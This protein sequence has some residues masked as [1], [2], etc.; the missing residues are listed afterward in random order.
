MTYRNGSGTTLARALGWF[1]IGLGA[2]E[3]LAPR[4]LATVLGMQGR[5]RL[6]Q[7]YGVR[8]VASGT[9]ILAARDP[10]PWVWIRVAGD[11]LDLATLAPALD[12]SN[13]RRQAAAIAV[14]AVT[15]VMLVDLLC[16]RELRRERDRPPRDYSNRSGFP[17]GVERAR[18]IAARQPTSAAGG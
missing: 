12:E 6:L 18:G 8:E 16:T 9:A 5:E 13:P 3:L 11:A 14:G 4:S 10:S 2:A 1:S 17:H 7:A 15:A